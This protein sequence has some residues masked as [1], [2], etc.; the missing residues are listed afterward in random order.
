M[1]TDKSL[2]PSTSVISSDNVLLP[3]KPAMS[4]KNGDVKRLT[5]KS[6]PPSTPTK[7]AMSTDNGDVERLTDK[8]SP[9]SLTL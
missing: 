6:S 8:S 4:S 7:P 5:N 9:L 1:L 2:H 3:S